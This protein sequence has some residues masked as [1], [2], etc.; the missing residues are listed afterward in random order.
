[1]HALTSLRFS[2]LATAAFT[3][4]LAALAQDAGEIYTLDEIV[5]SGSLT[6]V[7]KSET[8]ATVETVDEETLATPSE[9][10][11]D[12]LD[13]LPGVTVSKNGGI[14]A[15][16]TLR[17]R[18]LGSEYVGVRLNGID[19]T[20]PSSPQSAYDF[21][22]LRSYGIAAAEVVKGSQSALYGSE[23]IA[24]LIEMN[25]TP[26]TPGLSFSA[27]AGS[28][29]TYS[30]GVTNMIESETGH[31]AFS[32]SHFKTD[33]FS[34]MSDNDE[35][36]GFE[37]TFLTFG[38]E[39]DV[40]DLVT[41]GVT[42]FYRTSDLEY[43][44]SFDVGAT[45]TRDQKGVR[46]YADFTVG[47]FSHEVS[48]SFFQS[49]RVYGSGASS[50]Y[51]SSERKEVSYLG[52]TD[53]SAMTSLTFGAEYLEESFDGAGNGL[54]RNKAVKGELLM[55]PMAGLNL[56]A[57]LRYDDH[58]KLG[59]H[60]SG[61]L[62]A[63]WEVTP[64][65]I[66]RGVLGTG[67]RAPSLSERYGWGGNPDFTEETSRSSE[68]S[69]ERRF[70]GE[71]F[72]KATLFYTEIDDKIDWNYGAGAYEQIGGTTTSQGLEL[73]GRYSLSERFA[74]YGNYTYTD[75]ENRNQR[76]ARVPRHDATI[77]LDATLTARLSGAFEVQF[78]SDLKDIDTSTSTL[79]DLDDYTLFN[80]SLSYDLSD[81]VQLYLRADNLTDEDYETVSGYNTPGRS[82]YLGLKASF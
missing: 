4:P 61:R 45:A 17:I 81:K 78:V 73:S 42:G 50:Y 64:D 19:I 80:A 56:S 15:S 5:V 28:Y 27:E 29:G 40:N 33:G 67:F 57:A 48:A 60:V 74:L 76:A 26:Q 71:D 2:L 30:A 24:G 46:T 68:L 63:A 14:G 51:Y 37:E 75:A 72:A 12:I 49:D 3:L 55:E 69:V 35:K 25:T 54:D 70:L 79:F 66:V 22:G 65:W 62:A 32:L 20:D 39:H 77:G 23:A 1:M 52:S 31:I 53:L 16:A 59:E 44:T 18:G 6:P 47:Q 8:G 21:G 11:A 10:V 36:D 82:A 41:L 43:D 9:T 38:M 58:S 7:A 13:S 34:S